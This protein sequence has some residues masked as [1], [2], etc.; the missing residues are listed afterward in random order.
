MKKVEFTKEEWEDLVV[1]S[2]KIKANIPS[3][4]AGEVWNYYKRITGSRENQP[5]KCPSSANHWRRAVDTIK[6]YVREYEGK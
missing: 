1:I 4:I 5:C 2:E 6:N 3:S